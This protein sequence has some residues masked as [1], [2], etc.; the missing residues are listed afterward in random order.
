M[1]KKFTLLCVLLTASVGSN[2]FGINNERLKFLMQRLKLKVET[3]NLTKNLTKNKTEKNPKKT[4]WPPKSPLD[5]R[6]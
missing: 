5:K 6:R 4:V 2:C 3:K 1:L